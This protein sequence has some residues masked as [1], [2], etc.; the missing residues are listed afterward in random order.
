[1]G[2]GECSDTDTDGN[3]GGPHVER[4]TKGMKHHLK[5]NRDWRSRLGRGNRHSWLGLDF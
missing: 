2:F 4:H 3:G 1:M 5:R